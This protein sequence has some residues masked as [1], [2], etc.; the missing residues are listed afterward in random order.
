MSKNLT[1]TKVVQQ[2]DNSAIYSTN[3]DGVL[4]EKL[5]VLVFTTPETRLLLNSPEICG[6]EFQ[7]IFSNGLSNVLDALKL[8]PS[9]IAKQLSSDPIDILYILRGGLNFNLHEIIHKTLERTSEVSF[10]SSQRVPKE[11]GFDI[12]EA[13]YEKWSVQDQS[14]LCFGDI[15]ATGTTI[16]QAVQRTIDHHYQE[17][18]KPKRLLFITIGTSKALDACVELSKLLT[19]RLGD[20]FEGMTVLFV[21]QI[22]NLYEFDERLNSNHLQ[23][24]DFFRKDYPSTIEF[25][26]E[27]VSNPVCYLERCAIYDGG[28]RAFEPKIYTNNLIHYWESLK[29]SPLNI[30][31]YLLVK[32]NF[33]DYSLSYDDWMK[34]RIWWNGV[35]EDKLLA[36]YKKGHDSVN[37]LTNSQF[38]EV[39]ENR[40]TNLYKRRK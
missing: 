39:I 4:H 40:L 27:S 24:T 12:A 11:G 21:E 19:E 26:L 3:F 31:D 13:A 34:K 22:F 15:S 10:I 5:E 17:N 1:L 23:Y 30:E 14:L 29:K 32:S 25:E 18:K 36:L 20:S 9:D 16:K 37:H 6:S 33:M 38:D 28:S 35:S 8:Y 7:I 2:Q